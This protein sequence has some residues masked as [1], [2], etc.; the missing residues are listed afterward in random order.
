MAGAYLFPEAERIVGVLRADERQV[1]VILIIP[2][3]DRNARELK[4]QSDWLEEALNLFTEI[5]GG[6][7]V[8]R[9]VE[10]MFLV[11]AKNKKLRD[12]PLLVESY[13]AAS[14]VENPERLNRLLEFVKRMG[15]ATRQEAV[16]LVVNDYMHLI[17]KFR[18]A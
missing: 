5:F 17:T 13:A 16:A 1:V 2:S 9:A 14:R 15:R 6:A 3:H 8:F 4:D 18:Q 12:R 11:E 10:G 7:T